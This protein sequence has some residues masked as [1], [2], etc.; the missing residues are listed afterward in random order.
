MGDKR[1][2]GDVAWGGLAHLGPSRVPGY[3]VV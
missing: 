1:E 2:E 3:H